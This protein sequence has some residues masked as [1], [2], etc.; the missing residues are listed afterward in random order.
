MKKI[1]VMLVSLWLM[2]AVVIAQTPQAFKY[3]AVARNSTGNLIQNQLVAF[4]I[5][6]LQGSP[7]GALLYQERHTP[8]TNNYG[9]ANLDIGNGTVLSGIF[10]SINWSLGQMYIK[11]ELDPLGGTAYQ[12]MGT[13]QLLSVPYAL[14]SKTSAGMTLPY[15]GS[16]YDDFSAFSV[17]N[18]GSGNGITG[19]STNSSGYGLYGYGHT[20]VFGFSTEGYGVYGLGVYGV[21]GEASLDGGMG[22]HGLHNFTSGAGCGVLGQSSS[23]IGTAVKGSAISSTG[24]NY[25]VYGTT[26][27]PAGYGVFGSGPVTGIYGEGT[28]ESGESYGVIGDAASTNGIGV[29][30]RASDYDGTN[31][32]VFGITFSTNGIGVHGYTPLSNSASVAV[33]GE[34]N[35]QS[36]KGIY[37]KAINSFGT[38]YG[39]YGEVTS[40]SGYSGYFI[41]GRFYVSGKVGIGTTSADYPLVV[42]STGLSTIMARFENY[43]STDPV[44]MLRQSSNGSGGLYLYDGSNT[45]TIFLYGEGSSFI[46]GNLGIGTSSP[47]YKLQ[48]GVAGDGP[49][50]APMRGTCFRMP[51]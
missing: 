7:S 50:L 24:M 6:I 5:S 10:S 8:N 31:K 33:F 37:G 51:G 19:I 42:K 18:I 46:L 29:F 3:Q 14:Y 49:R 20:G 16:G 25:G 17:T 4:R 12:N 38:N 35:A 44:I 47:G 30:G 27:S 26:A 15:S 41:G 40:S 34:T 1:T 9:L 32:G 43:N 21:Y 48:V 39:V 36:G 45:N 2:T 11:V 13:M 23:P 28:N 22:V